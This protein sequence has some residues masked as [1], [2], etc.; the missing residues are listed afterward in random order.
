LF[1]VAYD[2]LTRLKMANEPTP[3]GDDDPVEKVRK[4]LDQAIERNLERGIESASRLDRTLITLSGGALVLS[5]TFIG[6]VAP[7]KSYLIL[8]FVAWACFIASLFCVVLSMHLIQDKLD[9]AVRKAAATLRLIDENLPAAREAAKKIAR[10]TPLSMKQV[11]PHTA[12][13][14]LNNCALA[15]FLVGVVMLGIFVGASLWA[16]SS[17]LSGGCP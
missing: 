4:S 12:I 10:D 15:S 2:L 3:E 8:L 13:E 17:T 5:M 6:R 1:A 16:S 7:G 14:R 11:T 9:K